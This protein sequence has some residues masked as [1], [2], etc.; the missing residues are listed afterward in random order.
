MSDEV[1]LEIFTH[2]S[3]ICF[4][5][6]VHEAAPF[7]EQYGYYEE[8]VRGQG[9]YVTRNHSG[10]SVL[11]PK[12]HR[13]FGWLP[14]MGLKRRGKGSAVISAPSGA[15]EGTPPRRSRF[16]DREWHRAVQH[17]AVDVTMWACGLALSAACLKG[18]W[19][20]LCL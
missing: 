8:V 13:G 7:A 12:R 14:K 19:W 9:Y 3:R 18:A 15:E 16:H 20:F 4:T 1:G 10:A 5:V 6:P 17:T 11:G 2:P